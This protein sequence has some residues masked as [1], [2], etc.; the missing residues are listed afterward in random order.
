MEEAKLRVKK[1]YSIIATVQ[2]KLRIQGIKGIAF[3][4][5]ATL[6]CERQRKDA[7]RF[8]DSGSDIANRQ[9]QYTGSRSVVEWYSMYKSDP[10]PT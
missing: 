5:L 9:K 10:I 1:C 8:W 2:Q 7:I 4:L 3:P 6:K